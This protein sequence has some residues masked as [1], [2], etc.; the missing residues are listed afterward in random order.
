MSQSD[1]SS[2]SRFQQI[3]ETYRMTKRADRTTGLKMLLAFIVGAAIG[4]GLFWILPGSGVIGLVMSIVGAV[5]FGFLVMMI[6]FSRKA[7]VA[8]Y[9]RL[10]G[11]MGGAYAALTMLR[12]GWN[13]KQAVAVDARS[14][15]MVHRVVGRPG[16]ILVGEGDSATRV[17]ALL[18]GEK[19]KTARVVP[20]ISI[21][22]VV[23]GRGEDQV[24]IPDLVKHLQK[25]PRELHPSDLTD[26]LNR[27]KALDNTRGTLPVPKGPMPTSMKGM[28]QNM[29]GR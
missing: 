17:R 28:R 27:L 16:V 8:G 7:K 6:V 12:R 5:L 21:H 25:L 2:M 18:A 4:F 9:A 14:K 10:E 23:S 15:S 1:P 19:R 11:Q 3:R 24:P 26:V 22:E 13:Y 20:D 29:R